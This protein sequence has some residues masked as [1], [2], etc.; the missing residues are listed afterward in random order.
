[1]SNDAKSYKDTLNLPT[2]DFP[3]K[4]SLVQREPER[5][6]K[7]KEI[8]LYQKVQ[9][10]HAGDPP[11]VL[12]DGP[13]FA[14]GDIHL[15]HVINKVLKDVVLRYQTMNGHATPYVPGW[16]CHG[17][18]IEHQVQ[19]KLG[20]K[21]REMDT[22]QVRRLCHEHAEKFIERQSEQFQRLGILGDWA[23]PYNTMDSRY[24]AATLDVF[25]RM[26]EHGLVYKKLKPVHWSIANR[27]ALADAELEYQDRDDPSVWVEFAAQN[28]GEFKS[29]FDLRE[30]GKVNFLIWTTT[31]WTLPANLAIA[32][33]P[34]V[35]Y[36]FVAY[37]KD[38]ERRIDVVA[39]KLRD[40]TFA[41][42]G[43]Q[44]RVLK[45]V[46]GEELDDIKYVHPFVE[47]R[48]GRILQADYVTTEDGT[49]LVHTAP[50]HGEEDYQT[51]LKY[52]LEVY[53]PVDPAGRFDS[54]TPNFVTGLTVWEGNP[55]IV[56][57]L[58]EL[59][60]LFHTR[61]IHHSY[62]HDW[63]SKT[64]T[65]F[66]ATEQWFV[67]LDT[68]YSVDGGV[69]K[70]LRNRA[71]EVAN[72][73]AFHPAW[74]RQRLLGML[75]NRPDWCVSRQRAWGLPIPVFYN[76]EGEALLTP[77]SVRAVARTFEQHG[78]DAW[79][80]MTPAELLG[81]FDPGDKFPKDE[82]R[83]ESDIFDVWLESG[84]SWHGVLDA[85]ADLP[86]VPADLYLEGS[87][88]HRGWF[89]LSLLAALGATGSAPFKGVLTHGFIVKPDGTKVS[90]SDKEYVTATQEIDRH[91]ADLLRLWTCSV[92]YTG[93]VKASPDILAKFGDEYRK[94][95]NTIR[96]LLGNLSDFVLS[97]GDFVD[98]VPADSLDGWMLHELGE[99]V[100]GV[101][102]AMDSYQ[103]HHAYRL[104]RDFCTVQIS[105]VYGNAMKD[106]LYCDLPQ[107]PAR[108]RSQS[109]QYLVAGALVQML[110]PML[111]F[112]ADEAWEHLHAETADLAEEHDV[113][114]PGV[115]MTG[116]PTPAD[117]PASDAY[118]LLMRLR[119]DALS[120]L[121][122]LKREKGLNKATDSEIVYKLTA[123]DRRLLEPFGVDLAD[124]VGAGN[125]A[126]ED[127]EKSAVEVVDRRDDYALCARSRKR[128][129]DVGSD[130]QYPDLSARD[131]AVMRSL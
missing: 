58:N 68:P 66:R 113:P 85:R 31:P 92:D 70:S 30:Q 93:D 8:D 89:Q 114:F 10:A 54:T 51:G 130:P 72:T 18:P 121:D 32:V 128:T 124:V 83:K 15:G 45:T 29:R 91:G 53:C 37:E 123:A 34:E 39:S 27:T 100:R 94:I 46:R 44:G 73:A 125:Y 107:S 17:L 43:V 28:P 41:L 59:G 50:G 1:M 2:T 80:K 103:I 110:A 87:D 82:L 106:R 95:R 38:G 23:R 122:A 6:A 16:D 62:P 24:E 67:S 105:Q 90:K 3:M 129:P 99:L 56:E 98:D 97:D 33:G 35:E 48:V 96:F 64:P 36:D 7:W 88:Q 14:N 55:V 119:D 42:R 9:E 69:E 78:S 79:F 126:V 65:I 131:A 52:G 60:V 25:A 40:K 108:Q 84:S 12:H 101:T 86:D 63:R 120:Q 49:G 26:V 21:L 76:G 112:T 75:Q 111:V 118:P 61:P 20:G 19:T 13:P 77:A 109:V 104:L 102:A 71:I 117:H 116:W 47:G 4:A 81:D 127:A 57:K 74:G 5:L 11:F 115:H 22:L